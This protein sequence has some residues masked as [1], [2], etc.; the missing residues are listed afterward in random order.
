VP[1]CGLFETNDEKPKP[2]ETLTGPAL[3]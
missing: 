3:P 1:Q 2:K